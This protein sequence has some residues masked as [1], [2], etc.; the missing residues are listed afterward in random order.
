M[1]ASPLILVEPVDWLADGECEY[2]SCTV[3]T[4]CRANFYCDPGLGCCLPVLS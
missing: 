1:G 2:E 3:H 4:D